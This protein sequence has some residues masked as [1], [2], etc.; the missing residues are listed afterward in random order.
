MSSPSQKVP[1]K[2]PMHIFVAGLGSV[3]L[4]VA[5]LAHSTGFASA[6]R[7]LFKMVLVRPG[8]RISMCGCVICGNA[9]L[10]G[11]QCVFVVDMGRGGWDL[12]SSV[13]WGELGVRWQRRAMGGAMG[14]DAA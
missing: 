5:E 9:E 6:H 3:G 2:P 1:P 4:G 12:S 13:L 7:F 14:R 11:G 10:V 8:T